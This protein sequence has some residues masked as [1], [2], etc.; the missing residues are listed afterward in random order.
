MEPQ[1]SENEPISAS[2]AA[3]EFA[4]KFAILSAFAYE[5]FETDPSSLKIELQKLGLEFVDAFHDEKIGTEA[6]LACNTEFAVLS[7]RGT[8]FNKFD[9]LTDLRCKLEFV[10]GKGAHSGFLA[11]FECVEDKIRAAVLKLGDTPLYVTGHSLGGALAVVAA[12]KLKSPNLHEC[13]TYGAPPVADKSWSEDFNGSLYQF[14]NVGDIVPRVMLVGP[15]FGGIIWALLW[16]IRGACRL[17]KIP[18]PVLQKW[19]EELTGLFPHLGKYH[20]FG[21][22]YLV[23][24]GGVSLE[25]VETKRF[26]LFLEVVS[27]K[28]ERAFQ[29]HKISL[30]IELLA[31][32]P[33]SSEVSAPDSITIRNQQ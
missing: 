4:H 15:I 25:Q 31:E 21:N 17:L 11:A 30:Y 23:D 28:W 32:R 13:Y 18:H 19:N 3:P 29:D 10:D 16:L 24:V 1:T 9:I 2:A 27:K 20:H 26:Q 7:F 14:V 12:H 6:Y 5:P 8:Q 22:S 33:T